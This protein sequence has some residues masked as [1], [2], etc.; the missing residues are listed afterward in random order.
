MEDDLSFE[1]FRQR[2]QTSGHRICKWVSLRGDECHAPTRWLRGPQDASS[3]ISEHPEVQNLKDLPESTYNLSFCNLHS[4]TAKEL[5]RR[6]RS[7]GAAHEGVIQ[8]FNMT[9]GK[10]I[11]LT[12]EETQD[13]Q[14]Y[15]TFS[16]EESRTV[17]LRYPD[18]T[19]TLNDDREHIKG[20]DYSLRWRTRVNTLD[21]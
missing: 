16:D 19:E 7:S 9:N 8:L 21:Q 4:A 10:L 15:S 12:L 5:L 6:S 18:G 20:K 17:G 11:D 14:Q 2:L 1:L 13:T 3:Y